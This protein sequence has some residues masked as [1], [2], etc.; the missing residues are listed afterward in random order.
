MTTRPRIGYRYS[1]TGNVQ[2][3]KRN[4]SR[5]KKI[6]TTHISI[7]G[8]KTLDS[9]QAPLS[10]CQR[11]KILNPPKGKRFLT[12]PE[13]LVNVKA[14]ISGLA[15][16]AIKNEERSLK[17]NQCQMTSPSCFLVYPSFTTTQQQPNRHQPKHLAG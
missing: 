11:Q 9:D 7:Q 10:S 5:F 2:T 16:H 8:R 13:Q 17:N 14:R 3:D 6:S 15:L 4:A 1:S 12:N